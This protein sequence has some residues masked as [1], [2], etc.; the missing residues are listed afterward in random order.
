MGR[1][2]CQDGNHSKRISPCRPP[3]MSWSKAGRTCIHRSGAWTISGTVTLLKNTGIGQSNDR[4]WLALL[5]SGVKRP[6][7]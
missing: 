6:Q 2:D 3:S 5:R 1:F 7:P 4:N